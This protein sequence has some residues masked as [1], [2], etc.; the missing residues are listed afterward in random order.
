MA[1]NLRSLNNKTDKDK[2]ENFLH[3]LNDNDISIACI[4]ETWFD[5]ESGTF[6]KSIKDSGYNLFHSFRDNQRGGGTAIMCRKGVD[7]KKGQSSSSKYESFEYTYAF[8][9]KP[10]D[11]RRILLMCVY[12]RQEIPIDTF[13]TEIEMLMDEVWEKAH[14]MIV[15]GDLNVWA[16]MKTDKKAKKVGKLFNAFGLSQTIEGATH[17][18]GHTLD[19]IYYNSEQLDIKTYVIKPDEHD[20]NIKTDHF[21]CFAELPIDNNAKTV[22]KMEYRD[23]KNIDT[24]TFRQELES[25][26]DEVATSDSNFEDS[27]QKYKDLTEALVE[28]HAPTK[29]ITLKPNEPKWMD[30]EYRQARCERRRLERRWRKTGRKEDHLLYI[31]QRNVCAKLVTSKRE[32]FYANQI[33]KAGNRQ[34]A[35]FQVV[36]NALDKK[37]ENVLPT[38]DD[39]KALANE[40]N[41]YYVNKIDKLRE[42]IPVE[43]ENDLIEAVPFQ[44]NKLSIFSPTSIDE[45][46]KILKDCGIKTSP[47]DPIPVSI[48]NN[49]YEVTLPALVSLINK[50][51]EEG[52]VD[53]I[54]HSVID[55]LLKKLNLDSENKKNYRPVN[56]LVFLSKLIERIVLSRIDD[57]LNSNNLQN[58]LQFGYKKHHST[59]TMLLGIVDE[60]LEAFD[61]NKFIVMM[62][63]DLSAAFDTIDIQK[64]LNILKFEIGIDG[65]AL[66]WCESFLTNRTQRVKINASYSESIKVKYGTPQGSVLGPRFFDIYVRSQPKIFQMCNF[67]STS[68]ADDSNGMK[69]F[70][71]TF[72]Y[73]TLTN[74]VPDC[75]AKITKWMNLQ[76]LKINPDKTEI[77]VFHPKHLS[78]RLLIGGTIIAKDECIRFSDSV[79][80]VGVFLDKNLNLNG[81][82]NKI[83]SQSYKLLKDL[84]SARSFISIKDTEILV[85]ASITSRLDYC[86]SLFYKMS[87]SNLNKLQ[88]VQNAAARLVLNRGRHAS[89]SPLLEQLHWLPVKSRCIF[90]I[91]LLMYKYLNNLAPKN[92]SFEYSVHN[93][94]P[95]HELMLKTCIAKSKYGEKRFSYCG[96]RLWNKLPVEIKKEDKIDVFKTK[97]KTLLFT[98]PD[99]FDL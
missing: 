75:L 4:T 9:K 53:G 71:I 11:T 85:N 89:A 30:K 48:L 86:N 2:L 19:H 56:N 36:E 35:L 91:L 79:K 3:V 25:I 6:S 10:N 47:E 96:P 50:S 99:V 31:A 22:V 21:P 95:Q 54:K 74:D 82:I 34:K 7:V 78:N 72:Q 83:V 49:I 28:K 60:L 58:Y 27:Y 94:R 44:G 18:S 93:H 42:S 80:N 92:M 73:N 98:K 81:H 61:D 39:P 13:C 51:L 57:H 40:F 1:W 84:K 67:K 69:K 65:V 20:F 76:W 62:F 87:K 66:K 17:I 37:A 46:S 24:D 5:A 33:S 55:P 88:K 68:Y 8:L 43:R 45:V 70:A 16:D 26:V 23:I 41:E 52:S 14:S 12:R 90:K 64:L 59:E 29:T 32:L 63:L 38:H 77:V 15:V 97:I